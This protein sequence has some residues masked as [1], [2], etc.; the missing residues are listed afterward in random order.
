MQPVFQCPSTPGCP[1]TFRELGYRQWAVKNAHFAATDYASVAI[2][3][4][5][6][7]FDD[8]GALVGNWEGAWWSDPEIADLTK[9]ASMWGLYGFRVVRREIPCRRVAS[10][11]DGLS[12]TILVRESAGRPVLY[13]RD[14]PAVVNDP[15]WLEPSGAWATADFAQVDRGPAADV[16]VDNQS[17]AASR[18]DFRVVP[19]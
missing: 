15:A 3:S 9:V 2:V 8:P 13:D 4:V 17:S 19:H 18:T 7:H 10:I 6:W 14:G 12:Q 16:N 11:E 5:I 1:R